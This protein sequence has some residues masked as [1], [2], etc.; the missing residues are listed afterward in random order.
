M[1]TSLFNLLCQSV[2]VNAAAQSSP[3]PL[4]WV[5]ICGS[6]NMLGSWEVAALGGVALLE[7]V[8]PCWS[9]CGLGGS[10]SLLECVLKLPAVRKRRPCWLPEEETVLFWLPL[11]RNAELSARLAPG[12]P[13]YAMIMD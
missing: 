1:L 11:D 3:G 8:W 13:S 7:W 6:L 4:L 5:A 9:R 2:I 12:L 10:A